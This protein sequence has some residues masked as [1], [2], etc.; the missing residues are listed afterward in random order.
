[1]PCSGWTE[2]K[3][4][5]KQTEKYKMKF[6]KIILFTLCIFLLISS[7]SAQWTYISGYWV[8]NV[9][10][11][12]MVMVNT[13]GSVTF[14]MPTGLI[15][16]TISNI[17]LVGNGGQGGNGGNGA[18]GGGGSGG[19]AGGNGAVTTQAS[20]TATGGA[21]Y[22]LTVGSPTSAFGLSA[23]AGSTGSNGVPAGSGGS[24]GGN[25]VSATSGYLSGYTPIPSSSS[26]G[27]GT[28]SYAGGTQQ[29]A[30]GPGGSG[31]SGY[32]AG[33]GGGGGG[34]GGQTGSGNTYNGG[35]AS[36]GTPAPGYIA[37]NYT[38]VGISSIPAPV[39]QFLISSTG[40]TAPVIVQF[41]D[42]T[43]NS[44]GWSWS[45]TSYINGVYSNGPTIFNVSQNPSQSFGTSGINT[46]YYI[47]ESTSN[48]TTGL[49]NTSFQ[50]CWI[51]TS[52]LSASFSTNETNPNLINGSLSV[53]FTDNTSGDSAV[54]WNY[55]DNGLNSGNYYNKSLILSIL[56]N[57]TPF[58]DISSYSN[59]VSTNGNSTIGPG[60]GGMG[61][62]GAAM[63][64]DG[65]FGDN[66]S[67]PSTN[68]NF[69]ASPY[70]FYAMVN[71]LSQY[72]VIVNSTGFLL[73]LQNDVPTLTTSNATASTTISGG[74]TPQNQWSSIEV[75]KNN[76]Y[77]YLS[78]NG[79]I[80]NQIP[81]TSAYTISISGNMRFGQ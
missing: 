57:I 41:T 17:V 27:P 5:D 20:Y 53:L 70:T 13:S 6:G 37:F 40:G 52:A 42:K 9:G 30:G 36:G 44:S 4:K 72:G 60:P 68:L 49:Y 2:K 23:S 26:G 66:V 54:N 65:I 19:Q 3:K 8:Q 80:V 63:Y 39:A 76:Q 73:T 77:I 14:T 28:G 74:Y 15:S 12:T 61:S 45:Y 33:S 43:T 35:G 75:M 81:L 25:G 67:V 32:G 79:N 78:V 51:N 56:G 38:N 31:A 7:A 11:T 21:Q 71:P 55:G 69:G 16:N 1:M 46:E 34:G 59:S 10:T 18:P 58:S 50:N 48:V 62:N 29:Y 24:A 64:F 22:T 47:S